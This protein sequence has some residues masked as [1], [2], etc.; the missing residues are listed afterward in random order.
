MLRSEGSL[1]AA[2]IV[3]AKTMV[4]VLKWAGELHSSVE[5]EQRPAASEGRGL[6]W[7]YSDTSFFGQDH[8]SFEISRFCTALGAGHL[9]PP[10]SLEVSF[11]GG[12]GLYLFY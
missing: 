5:E 7:K 9:K 3:F 11:A 6:T 2:L 1:L 8:A 10:V 4:C 12:W